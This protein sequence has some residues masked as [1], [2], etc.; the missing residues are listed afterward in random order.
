[1]ISE[2][3]KM[4]SIYYFIDPFLVIFG[5]FSGQGT[6][7]KNNNNNKKYVHWSIFTSSNYRDVWTEKSLS[8]VG[9]SCITEARCGKICLSFSFSLIGIEMKASYK[10]CWRDITS[11]WQSRDW[12]IMW[13]KPDQSR[14]TGASHR[15]TLAEWN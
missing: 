13:F 4:V 6:F 5:Y 10:P 1:M 7:S 3:T 8:A 14:G 9:N 2:K 12:L 15:V 11:T